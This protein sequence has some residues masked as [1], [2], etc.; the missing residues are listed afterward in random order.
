[1]QGLTLSVSVYD[2]SNTFVG[3]LG[4]DVS[5]ALLMQ[6]LSSLDLMDDAVV[7]VSDTRWNIIASSLGSL[8][9]D[10]EYVV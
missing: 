7:L 5:M 3:V 10:L 6:R 1:M 8:D 2:S 9:I 4:V